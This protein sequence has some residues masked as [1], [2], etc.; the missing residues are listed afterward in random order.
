MKCLLIISIFFTQI[1]SIGF[2]QDAERLNGTYGKGCSND[3]F[4]GLQCDTAIK[5]NYD[6]SQIRIETH[7]LPPIEGS[8]VYE[9]IVGENVEFYRDG[10]FKGNQHFVW[11][12]EY[13]LQMQQCQ[14]NGNNNCY[15][16]REDRV[17]QGLSRYTTLC[18]QVSEFR[19]WGRYEVIFKQTTTCDDGTDWTFMPNGNLYLLKELEQ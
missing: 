12:R 8:N 14:Q 2:A 11:T 5:I 19:I 16:L 9:G 10:K 18:K 17:E 4:L 15:E 6:N 1:V 3:S 7:N 13:N